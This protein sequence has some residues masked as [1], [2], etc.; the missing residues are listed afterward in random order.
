MKVPVSAR[1]VYSKADIKALVDS[2]ATDNFIHP[3]FVKR[4]GMGTRQ[5]EKPKRIFNIDNTNNRAGQI[6]HYLDLDVQTNGI[7]KEMRFLITD[8]GN[9]DILL[10]YPWLAVYEPKFSWRHGTI[11]ERNLPIVIRTVNPRM[12]K[13]KPVIARLL[14]ENQKS[15]ILQELAKD[16]SV[17]SIATDTVGI[18]QCNPI[19]LQKSGQS[20]FVK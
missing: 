6:T 10:G 5:L 12:A 16:S 3:R 7:Y 19:Q 18:L 15:N 20:D 2:G 17:A 11:D 8:I 14:T 9:E 1:T 4:M 13:M